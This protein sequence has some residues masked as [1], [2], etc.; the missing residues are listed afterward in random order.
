MQTQGN[1]HATDLNG[2]G[3]SY[4]RLQYNQ[5][6][7]HA[8]LC[9][10][11]QQSETWMIASVVKQD[12]NTWNVQNDAGFCLNHNNMV[13]VFCQNKINSVILKL[14]FA[15][16][17]H[18]QQL[19]EQVAKVEKYLS[20][21]AL[22]WLAPYH[23]NIYIVLV[24]AVLLASAGQGAWDQLFTG[25]PPPP[26]P[27][28]LPSPSGNRKMILWT[29]SPNERRNSPNSN[30]R[31]KSQKM[32]TWISESHNKH[33][34]VKLSSDSQREITCRTTNFQLHAGVYVKFNFF[35]RENQ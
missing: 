32:I 5:T 27:R 34:H 24:V 6:I 14:L 13:V 23:L 21:F 28:P 16:I 19:K 1:S 18:S 4:H 29:I 10:T 3:L 15:W 22:Q 26:P 35:K 30:E 17:F 12:P 9:S 33:Q 2:N 8:T 7:T 31:L 11:Q 25:T 20:C